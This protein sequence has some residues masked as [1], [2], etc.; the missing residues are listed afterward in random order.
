MSTGLILEGVVGTGKTTLYR[1]LLDHP[2]FVSRE[3]KIALPEAYTERA[4]EHL[5]VRDLEASLLLLSQ[6]T[7][8]IGGL[9]HT[10]SES[11]FGRGQHEDLALTFLLERFHLTHAVMFNEGRFA[12]YR[13]VDEVLRFLGARLVLCV[14]DESVLPER[15]ARTRHHRNQLW[16][17]YLDERIALRTATMTQDE[18]DRRVAVHFLAQQ[19][20]LVAMARQSLL[21]TLVID[22]TAGDWLMYSEQIV[23]FW[24]LV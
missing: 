24:G 1:H 20:E 10:W 6:I 4:I 12:A 16:N 23:R 17:D 5:P 9:N 14:L 13:S 3:T 2:A 8:V 7:D 21:P 18:V 15:I 11:K 19:K 22:T